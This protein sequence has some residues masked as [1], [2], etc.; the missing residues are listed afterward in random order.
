MLKEYKLAC[1]IIFKELDCPIGRLL[2]AHSGSGL[3]A[4]QL[5]VSGGDQARRKLEN[6]LKKRFGSIELVEDDKGHLEEAVGFLKAYFEAP[7][8]SGLFS[9]A[10]DPGGTAFQQM[11]WNELKLIRPGAVLSYGEIARRIGHP[12]AL[13]AVG[14][15]CGANPL[16][17]IV[18]CHRVVGSGGRLGGFGGG[19]ELKKRLL[20]AEGWT[21]FA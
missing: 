18:P 3:C 11:V 10:L 12:Q 19:V 13:R 2:L 14:S 9:G 15:A 8:A 1:R 21:M 4:I 16:P 5:P 17:I 7:E 6:S 20:V